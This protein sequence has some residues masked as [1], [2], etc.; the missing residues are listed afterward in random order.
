M[1]SRSSALYELAGLLFIVLVSITVTAHVAQSGGRGEMMFLD[2]D[3]MIVPMFTQSLL[4][5]TA[6]DWAMSTTFFIPEIGLYLLLSLLGMD[7]IQLQFLA[8]VLNL[9]MLYVSLRLVARWTVTGNR[10][11]L[12]GAI[13]PFLA[14]CVLILWE[15]A[16]DRNSLELASL[17]AL[18]SYYS[19][20]V[21]AAIL[22]V[23]LAQKLFDSPLMRKRDLGLLVAI[24]LVSTLSNPIYVAWVTLP[25]AIVVGIVTLGRSRIRRGGVVLGGL[26]VVTAVGCLARLPLGH[27]IAAAG[28][29]YLKPT[30]AN[31]SLSYY[32]Q[33]LGHRAATVGG[34][35]S[36]VFVAAIMILG[37]LLS[38]TE[39]RR[40][41]SRADVLAIYSWLTPLITTFGFIL[42]GSDAARYLQPWVFAP[43]LSLIVLAGRI[44][45]P[46]ITQ[47]RWTVLIGATV[48]L[49]SS[50]VFAIASFPM[51]SRS[52]RAAEDSLACTVNWINKSGKVGA[53]QFWSIRAVKANLNDPSQLVQVDYR[54]NGYAWLVDR[55]DYEHSAASFLLTDSQTYPFE[56]PAQVRDR[57]PTTVDCGRFQIA[58]YGTSR[59]PIGPTW[60]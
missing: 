52:I 6:T 24:A 46:R 8:G 19:G 32:S 40:A 11:S 41:T 31:E 12:V 9:V 22:T 48:A 35:N 27:W 10:R 34:I 37:I 3:S 25:L 38:V 49:V 58:D 43:V 53:G 44:E 57:E 45:A 50:L 26:I 39:F 18:T 56:L 20:T 5:G 15:G 16:G 59:I 23:G 42:L 36:I 28:D 13:A 17:L 60:P 33:L 14:Y 1:K 29:S 55:K 47:K 54:M 30:M 4:H 2:G 7:L 21:F 51:A